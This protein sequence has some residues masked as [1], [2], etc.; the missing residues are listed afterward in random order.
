M[1]LDWIHCTTMV[2]HS[3]DLF[4]YLTMPHEIVI[5]DVAWMDRL[6]DDFLERQA[7]GGL[8]TPV[9]LEGFLHQVIALFIDHADLSGTQQLHGA[10]R[11][12]R[13]LE[14]IE[15]HL[16]DKI[17][18]AD[19]A[20][21]MQFHPGYFSMQFTRVMGMGPTAYVNQRRMDYARRLLRETNAALDV[22]ATAVGCCDVYY[23]SR[24]FKR[25]MGMTPWQYRIQ[26]AIQR[27]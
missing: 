11:F 6:W 27:P 17:T 18:L 25:S 22:I 19:L 23:F 24:L 3:L 14:Y 12:H 20:S 1:T 2:L 16:A 26:A 21:L 7:R 13:V 4:T 10:A 15:L 9:A 8:G 5:A